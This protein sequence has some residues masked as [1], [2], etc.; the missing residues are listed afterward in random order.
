MT[1]RAAIADPMDGVVVIGEGEK[2][3]APMLYNGERVG[4]GSPPQVDIAVDPVDGT[5]LTAKSLPNASGVAA[6]GQ[7]LR[8]STWRS[9][10]W[11][12]T[13][14][15]WSTSRPRSRRTCAASPRP[16]ART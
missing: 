10:P 2:D 1:S 16:R 5:T 4:S 8:A 7:L 3:N 15:T 9:W 11:A 12:A 14:P 13:P 6:H